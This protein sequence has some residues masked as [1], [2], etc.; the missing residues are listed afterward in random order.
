MSEQGEKLYLYMNS[1]GESLSAQER[2]K[3][4]IVGRSLDKLKA[5]KMWE[6]WQN[7]FWRVKAKYDKNADRGF[8]EFLK[9]ATIIH[10]CS[11]SDTNIKQTISAGKTKNRIEEI[12]DYIR[13]E[14][15]PS[16]RIRQ[17]DNRC[18]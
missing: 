2:I 15:D 14:K 12:E 7:F 13:I 5:G 10:L 11:F 18:A 1:R 8:F 4:V 16:A 6:D 17:A 3:S 9:W